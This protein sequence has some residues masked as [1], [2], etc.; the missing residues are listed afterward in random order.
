MHWGRTQEVE[1]SHTFRGRLRG[2]TQAARELRFLGWSVPA[3]CPLSPRK[4][5]WLP[6][7]IASPRVS[8][9]IRPGATRH[10]PF[11]LTGP[12]RVRWR[13]GL[14]VRLPGLRRSDYS[15]PRLFGYLSNEQLQGKLL[16]A[17]KIS[18]A[19]PGVPE[20]CATVA[21][22]TFCAKFCG[23]QRGESSDRNLDEA[24]RAFLQVQKS[25]VF[26]FL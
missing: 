7:L 4:A 14:R 20:V 9:F 19:Y 25:F 18:Q 3:C 24:L 12:Y 17:Y 21:H 13:Y 6:A 2:E 15:D 22:F 8:G 11:A 26:M 10:F 1:P 5:P 16:S 23:V